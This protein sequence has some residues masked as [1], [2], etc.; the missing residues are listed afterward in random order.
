ME[1]EPQPVVPVGR[2]GVHHRRVGHGA[3]H[4]AGPRLPVLGARAAEVGAVAHLGVHGVA[5][6]HHRAVVLVGLLPGLQPVR[7]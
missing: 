2:P 1:G 6:H 3:D 4:G 5:E 7:H